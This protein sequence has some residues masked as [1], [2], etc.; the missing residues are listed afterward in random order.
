MIVEMVKDTWSV[1]LF[2]YIRVAEAGLE[3]SDE[4][5]CLLVFNDGWTKS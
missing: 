4:T 5:V 2:T 3:I 1:E